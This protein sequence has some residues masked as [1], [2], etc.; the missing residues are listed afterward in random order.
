MTPYS[1]ISDAL[2]TAC[3]CPLLVVWW[4][5]ACRLP[6]LPPHQNSPLAPGCILVHAPTYMYMY[7]CKSF[8]FQ[9]LLVIY[10]KY[11]WVYKT[12]LNKIKGWQG[13][14]NYISVKSKISWC[15]ASL[16]ILELENK[17]GKKKFLWNCTYLKHFQWQISKFDSYLFQ[18][19][20]RTLT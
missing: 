18:W 12:N 1:I 2:P 19:Q 11:W 5:L 14:P 16:N 4:S 17:I 20:H 15:R 9:L 6:H 7:S 8:H 10:S 3:R 13:S